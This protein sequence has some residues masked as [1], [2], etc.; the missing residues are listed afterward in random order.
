M[1]GDGGSSGGCCSLYCKTAKKASTACFLPDDVTIY[2]LICRH[3]VKICV[4]AGNVLSVLR[5]PDVFLA[6]GTEDM[7]AADI[8]LADLQVEYTLLFCCF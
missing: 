6:I 3:N 5:H 8:L 4:V 7:G 2:V 1:P